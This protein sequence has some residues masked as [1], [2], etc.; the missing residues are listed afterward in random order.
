MQC[1]QNLLHTSAVE[2]SVQRPKVARGGFPFCVTSK[3][4]FN[5]TPREL[6]GLL[7]FVSF[8]RL[9][10]WIKTQLTMKIITSHINEEKEI[11][12]KHKT[13]STANQTASCAN[14]VRSQHN[15]SAL[16]CQSNVL[17]VHSSVRGPKAKRFTGSPHR[18]PQLTSVCLAPWES[19]KVVCNWTRTHRYDIII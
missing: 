10:P 8:E 7:R 5:N 16:T 12:Y 11:L 6:C 18:Y 2:L 14:T 3:V 4:S 15:R 19:I 13:S 17:W 9:G 1:D